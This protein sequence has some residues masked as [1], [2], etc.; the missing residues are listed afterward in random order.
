[1]IRPLSRP[2]NV[3][4]SA[5][6]AAPR[7]PFPQ[8]RVA[9]KITNKKKCT[10]RL[11]LQHYYWVTVFGRNSNSKPKKSSVAIFM[12]RARLTSRFRTLM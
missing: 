10:F 4:R 1:M 3:R 2:P 9:V 5:L 6:F 7:P 12:P 8:A 11:C